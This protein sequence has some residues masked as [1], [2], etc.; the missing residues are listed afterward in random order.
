MTILIVGAGLSGCVLAQKYAELGK[1][2]VVLEKRDYIGGN[3]YDYIDKNWIL[4][5]LV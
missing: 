4:H 5:H 2:V 3:C 1:E